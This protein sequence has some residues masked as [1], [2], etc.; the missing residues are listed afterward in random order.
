[1]QLG[2]DSH[3]V[4]RNAHH[5]KRVEQTSSTR[6]GAEFSVLD[7]IRLAEVNLVS[8]SRRI[9]IESEHALALWGSETC[10]S[11]DQ[12]IDSSQ[13]SLSTVFTRLDEAVRQWITMDV[14]MLLAR[15]TRICGDQRFRVF[16]GAVNSDSCRRFHVDHFRLRMVTTYCGP[17]TEWVPNEAVNRHAVGVPS[18]CWEQANRE[19]VRD[20][21]AVR[22]A[23][24]GDVLLMKG[25][26]S[27]GELGAVHRSPP[28]KG[29]GR[30]RVVLIANTI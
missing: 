29:T 17:G 25:A 16:F 21:R 23:Q 6:V 7:Q 4:E 28:I 14:A 9:P 24:A 13:Y 18:T 20:S 27:A 22:C 2:E 8:W 26:S 12:V 15:F 10:P 3:L 19:T 30:T 5:A 11:F 1:M